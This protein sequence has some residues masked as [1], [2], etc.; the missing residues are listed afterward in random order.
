MTAFDKA[1]ALIL[2]HEGGYVNDPRDPGGE[3]K[4]GI[5]KRAYPG[6]NIKDLAVDRAGELYKRDYWDKLRCDELPPAVAVVA[7]DIAVNQGPGAAVKILQEAVRATQDGILGPKTIEAAKKMG[8][9]AAAE[10]T[11]IRIRRYIVTPNFATYGAGWI[12]RAVTTA[13]EAV[14]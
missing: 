3:T 4:Y 13:V 14:A 8:H 1:L 11:A 2:Q 12:R 7:F 9:R 10:M 6:E 5:S